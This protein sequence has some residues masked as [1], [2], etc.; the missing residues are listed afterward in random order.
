MQQRI[1]D[2]QKIGKDIQLS[3]GTHET[4][5]RHISQDE[6]PLL[7]VYLA[8]SISDAGDTAH[9]L[10]NFTS[11]T[12]RNPSEMY[13]PKATGWAGVLNE[14]VSFLLITTSPILLWFYLIAWQD[15]D[16]SLSSAATALL[17]EGSSFLSSRWPSPTVATTAGY[18]LW[19]LVQATLYTC[20]PAPLHRAPRTPGGRRLLY[21]LNGLRAWALTVAAASAAAYYGLFDPAVIAKNWVALFATVNLYAFALVGVFH[22][23]ARTS[24]DH[25]GDTWLTGT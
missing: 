4:L 19:V 5:S 17:S 6:K 16:A 8:K 22:I 25:P 7:L 20:I 2:I 1:R 18:I 3:T 23:K 15:F 21:R 24:P 14:V 9:P 10:I 12:T 13:E 11:T